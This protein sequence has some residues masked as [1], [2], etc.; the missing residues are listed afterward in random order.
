MDPRAVR[1]FVAGVGV[2]LLASLAAFVL[3]R[4]HAPTP[5]VGP[6]PGKAP[7]APAPG[8]ALDVDARL[9]TAQ[10][11]LDRHDYMAAWTATEEVL[12]SSPG[13]PRAMT[14]QA[15]VRVEMGQT[16]VALRML[17]EARAKAPDS[18]A[19]Y[20]YS[21]MAYVRLGRTKEAEALIGEA[22]RRFPEQAKMLDEDF[23]RMKALP[24]RAPLPGDNAGDQNPHAAMAPLGPAANEPES[25]DLADEVRT[26]S[27]R[28]EIDPALRAELPA[29]VVMFV[30]LREAGESTGPVLATKKVETTG[31]PVFFEVG[32]KDAPGGERLPSRVL[33]EGRVDA[34]GDPLTRSVSDPKATLDEVS[35]GRFDLRLL[36]RRP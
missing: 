8:P 34:D 25:D 20:A 33:V 17:E 31:F 27:G 11:A 28:L 22:K 1:G 10:A 32:P 21:A 3:L 9:D 5:A 24:V 12:K 23:E 2:V 16:D 13:H 36:L 4:P 15:L 14:Y 7:A 18:I 35:L 19:V 29:R 6:V 26:V 30:T